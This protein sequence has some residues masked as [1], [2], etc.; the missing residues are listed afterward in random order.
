MNIIPDPQVTVIKVLEHDHDE[1]AGIY[2]LVIGRELAVPAHMLEV[3]VL[4]ESGAEQY[5]E[6][7]SE[8]GSVDL[9]LKTTVETVPVQIVAHVDV[10]DYVFADDDDRWLDEHGQ[11]RPDG[12]VAAEQRALVKEALEQPPAQEGQQ[13]APPVE[14]RVM[15]GIGEDL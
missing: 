2:R 13:D 5:D 8:D 15:P 1:R 7:A 12:D 10:K 3:P 4:D 14:Q 6:V 11:R 9:V